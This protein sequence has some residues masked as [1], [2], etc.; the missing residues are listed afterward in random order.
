MAPESLT[1]LTFT[2]K[3]DV[4]TYGVLLWEIFSLADVPYAGLSW[5]ANFASLLE[6]GLRLPK[7]KHNVNYLFDVMQ[8]CWEFDPVK[9]PTFKMLLETIVRHFDKASNT[10]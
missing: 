10:M 8:T 5:R 2:E 6:N 7:P 3:T 1:K 9:R 4:W